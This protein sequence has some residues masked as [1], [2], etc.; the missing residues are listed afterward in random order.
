[1]FYGSFYTIIYCLSW[2]GRTIYHSLQF[3]R[4]D[5]VTY[6]TLKCTGFLTKLLQPPKLISNLWWYHLILVSAISKWSQLSRNINLNV[7][8]QSE[9][10]LLATKVVTYGTVT[11]RTK[12]HFLK[13]VCLVTHG[14]GKLLHY[15]NLEV[16][17]AL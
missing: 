7:S 12:M 16:Y 5:A 3:R 15:T 11:Y 10:E 9:L 8:N 6:G 14:H 13:H 2:C 4:N 1:M 17:I